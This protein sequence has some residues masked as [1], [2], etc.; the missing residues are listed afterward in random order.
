MGKVVWK[1]FR[2]QGCLKE[3]LFQKEALLS[4][5]SLTQPL[6]ID[7]SMEAWSWTLRRRSYLQ[8]FHWTSHLTHTLC[9]WPMCRQQGK[10]CG[11]LS[12]ASTQTVR[13]GSHRMEAWSCSSAEQ[14]S[15]KHILA[16]KHTSANTA[17]RKRSIIR[18]SS[19]SIDLYSKFQKPLL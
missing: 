17:K 3:I 13:L 4:L 2:N 16:N 19:L 5:L 7:R 8:E 18:S 14:S 10:R 12:W 1:R 6:V 11:T 15:F 9:H